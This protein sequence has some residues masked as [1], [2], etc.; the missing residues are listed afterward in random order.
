M[1]VKKGS[2]RAYEI[3]IWKT[4]DFELFDS[5]RPD[6]EYPDDNI[7]SMCCYDQ[8]TALVT[9]EAAKCGE[10]TDGKIP[11]RVDLGVG[12]RLGDE[13]D[14]SGWCGGF[15]SNECKRA[16]LLAKKKK[17]IMESEEKMIF[18]N[19]ACNALFEMLHT[20]EDGDG[21][22]YVGAWSYDSVEEF[23]EDFRKEFE[24]KN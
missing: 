15:E 10:F 9:M 5:L 1:G 4:I 2:K 13:F 3:H 23:I 18:L 24:N 12:Y 14:F 20:Y 8:S 19:D 21:H 11:Y 22:P 17:E 16:E 7:I 6:E